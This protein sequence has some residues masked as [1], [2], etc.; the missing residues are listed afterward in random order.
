[1]RALLLATALTAALPAFA[2]QHPS[3]EKNLDHRVCDVNYSP[4]EVVEV[5]AAVGDTV[6]IKVADDQII[7]ALAPSDKEHLKYLV[8]D[9]AGGNVMWLKARAP[10]PP[11]PIAFRG[12]KPDGKFTDYI[13]QW[14]AVAPPEPHKTQVAAAGDVVVEPVPQ[15]S[16]TPCWMVRFQYPAEEAAAKK[17]AA[18]A[19]YQRWKTQQAE[20]AL[21]KATETLPK[22]NVRYV[23]VGDASIGPT[24][25]Y[26]DGNTTELRFPGNLR[27]PTIFTVTPDGKERQL[28]GLTTEDGGILRIH[29][30]LPVIRMRDG[31]RVLCL[32]NRGYDAIGINP[33]TGTTSP[34]VRREANAR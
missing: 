25:I 30:T 12:M 9:K 17:A 13:L 28:S 22:R 18:S 11:Q 5:V 23:A 3:G 20:I 27:I 21:R 32:W 34:D 7:A 29:G 6:T 14:T 4:N 33:A 16:A 1:M 19:A 26:D 31:D 8:A 24:E 2:G 15:A 10:M